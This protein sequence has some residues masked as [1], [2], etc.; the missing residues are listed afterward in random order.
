[1]TCQ[2]LA[3]NKQVLAKKFFFSLFLAK[4]WKQ[5]NA[6]KIWSTAKRW[7]G[8]RRQGRVENQTCLYSFLL[9]LLFFGIPNMPLQET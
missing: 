5:A 3:R 8:K 1:M 7:K 9:L 6:C 2:T 4:V